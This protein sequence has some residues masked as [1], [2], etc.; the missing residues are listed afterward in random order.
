MPIPRCAGQDRQRASFRRGAGHARCAL[1]RVLC[2]VATAAAA[3]AVG[4]AEA[5]PQALMLEAKVNGLPKGLII[6][7]RL[8]AGRM[9]V[10]LS[11]L[12][13][14]GIETTDLAADERGQ[15]ALD[16]VPGLQ[17]V[18]RRDTQE[19]QLQADPGR[20]IPEELGNPPERLPPAATATGLVVN[21]SAH[22]QLQ[23]TR[24][25]DQIV[26]PTAM[27]RYGD[28]STFKPTSL[29]K[30]TPVVPFDHGTGH[31]TFTQALGIYTDAHLFTPWGTLYDTGFLTASNS[32]VG[33]QRTFTRMDTA[34]VMSDPSVPRSI[35][36]GDFITTAYVA[37]RS[38]R[39]GGI[40]VRSDYSL[41][42]DVITFPLPTLGGTA[43][44]PSA[45]DL[46]INNVHQFNGE[47]SGGPFQIVTPPAITGA[48]DARIVVEDPLGRKVTTAMRL[49]V[50][51]VL[52]REGLSD[53][54]FEAGWFRHNYGV[55]SND[56]SDR[57]VGNALYRYG[58]DDK[59]TLVAMSQAGPGLAVFGV[60]STFRILD[61]GT[62]GLGVATDF[63]DVH[64]WATTARY[65]YIS[66]GWSLALS[67]VH[68][69]NGF[70]DLGALE[71]VSFPSRQEQAILAFPI[72]ARQNVSVAW[73]GQEIQGQGRA[74]IGSLSYSLGIGR[75]TS[76]FVQAYDDFEHAHASGVYLGL[77][78]SLDNGRSA[79]ANATRTQDHSVVSLGTTSPVDY[80]AGGFGWSL[81]ADGDTNGDYLHAL[82]SG[83]YLGRYGEVQLTL[84]QFR[85]ASLQSVDARGAL[86]F[87]DGTLLASRAVSDSFAMVST[88]GVGGIP[89]IREN[90][91]VGTTNDSGHFVVPDLHSYQ[92][93]RL[94]IDT[95]DLP[96]ELRVDIDHMIVVPRG[97][98]GVLAHFPVKRYGGASI[99]LVG[100]DRKPLPVGS[101]VTL[102]ETGETAPV[103]YDGLV[104][105]DALAPVNHLRVESGDKACVVE[106]RFDIKQTMATIGPFVCALAEERLP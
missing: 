8:V 18:Y 60:G 39:L 49:Y 58:L 93:N 64:R 100:K 102:T 43:V 57:P 45:V 23:S 59:T 24:E 91:L 99:I 72:G 76:L 31:D 82:A 52:L 50:D 12:R 44:V 9:Y 53:Y 83:D 3:A 81:Q 89:V 36:L 34:W 92:A 70:R 96:P 30:D 26:A 67:D 74:S 2:L 7:T 1:A 75:R 56:Y 27:S 38:V 40:Q 86:V 20:L 51:P 73:N 54:S 97:G 16:E 14:I 106:V 11:E 68:A 15:V 10:R 84:E 46:Y 35:L 77:S 94:E 88:D 41:R 19:I 33:S 55:A 103:G 104:F 78:V 47:A 90:R 17:Y 21:Y 87:M 80:D 101:H 105:F 22:L 61:S 5:P 42:P 37:S 4:A 6:E 28:D 62:I 95:V 48:G 85:R 71:G 79:Y 32:L 25:S 63:D 66:Q 29:V 69:F 13:A 65:Q 98:A